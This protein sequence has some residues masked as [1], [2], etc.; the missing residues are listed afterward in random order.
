MG[1]LRREPG[2][3][4]GVSSDWG[5]AADSARG[6]ATAP[7]MTLPVV[8][9]KPL[10]VGESG[11][12]LSGMEFLNVECDQRNIIRRTESV[13]GQEVPDQE[14]TAKIKTARRRAALLRGLKLLVFS[15]E[16]TSMMTLEL[17]FLQSNKSTITQKN[18]P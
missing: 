14:R 4:A 11:P 12:D 7:A 13:C 1:I 8:A 17:L 10:R 3:A 2:A 18:Y 15:P 16:A 5:T 9:R 6:A